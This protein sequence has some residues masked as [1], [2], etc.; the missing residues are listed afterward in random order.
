MSK[1]ALNS[2]QQEIKLGELLHWYEKRVEPYDPHVGERRRVMHH[3]TKQTNRCEQTVRG[4]ERTG[5]HLLSALEKEAGRRFG[6]L[7][8][9]LN[10][11][12]RHEVHGLLRRVAQLEERLTR[13]YRPPAD[14]EL[15]HSM[16]ASAM[17][18]PP[19]QTTSLKRYAEL[20]WDEV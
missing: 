5:K 1:S 17:L 16:N 7:F 9:Q 2:Y 4:V 10:V 20:L 14:H 11:A 15:G 13:S 18:G 12:S 6:A 8:E 19:T 3:A